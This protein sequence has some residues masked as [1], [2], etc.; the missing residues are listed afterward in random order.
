V[1]SDQVAAIRP[2]IVELENAARGSER[3]YFAKFEVPGRDGIWIEVALGTVNFA[4]LYP[5]PP[6]GRLHAAGV[7]E[8][9]GQVLDEWQ[10]GV[11]AAFAY[12]P[13]TASH[14]VASFID[15][16]LGKV[17]GCGDDYPIDIEIARFDSG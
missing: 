3:E 16:V 11:F 1:G 12:D 5:E 10:P 4:Y 9:P 17:F 8:L 14:L 2:A 6:A 15:Q 13:A 7:V